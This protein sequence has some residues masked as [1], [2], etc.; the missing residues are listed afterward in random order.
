MKLGR[1]MYCA[2][3]PTVCWERGVRE[4]GD[5]GGLWGTVEFS[6][7]NLVRVIYQ[8]AAKYYSDCSACVLSFSL[9]VLML[10]FKR[11]H[12]RPPK[13]YS[14]ERKKLTS[15]DS[16][17][18]RLGAHKLPVYTIIAGLQWCHMFAAHMVAIFWAWALQL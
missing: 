13:T 14:L 10:C 7:M 18:R 17:I 5:K 16:L 9:T 15:L 11:R 2:S 12:L 3:G 6:C 4:E 1:A 8:P